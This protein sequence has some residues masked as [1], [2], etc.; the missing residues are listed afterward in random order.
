MKKIGVLGGTFNPIHEGHIYI[1]KQAMRKLEL[2]EVLLVP[3]KVSPFRVNEDIVS[4]SHRYAMCM[5][6]VEKEPNIQ[7]TDIENTLS[8]P[9]YTV[10]TIREL[11][12]DSE[13]EY[14]LL[15]GDDQAEQFKKW[16]DYREILKMVKVAV[17]SRNNEKLDLDFPH[18]MISCELH[19]ASAT[20]IRNGNFLY[21]NTDVKDYIL[22]NE[23]YLN[24]IVRSKMSEKRYL[25][26]VSVQKL[27]KELAE[28][29]GLDIHKASLAGLLH[30]ICKEMN[31]EMMEE[32]ME[33]EDDWARS[34]HPNVH[35][36]FVGARYVEEKLQIH[37]TDILN[38]IRYHTTGGIDNP[39]VYIL[40]IAD[41]TEPTRGYDA[42]KELELAK[43]DLKTAY[44]FV[45]CKQQKFIRKEQ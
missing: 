24:D 33:L 20:E 32:Y 27:S 44:D 10:E 17:F 3:N 34:T 39:Y 22:R 38:A 2:D 26:S 21:L 31:K 23:L 30:D 28:L 43:V 11:T 40:F 35:H 42:T 19:P 37:D 1:A 18:V 5:K 45:K 41:K 36:Q 6:A 13:D 25:H 8:V 15:I 12:K 4:F 7:V 16:K 14:Y 29:H 9:S